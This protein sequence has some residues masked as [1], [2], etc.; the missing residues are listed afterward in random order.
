MLITA[1]PML[2]RIIYESGIANTKIG[3]LTISAAAFDDAVAW[4]MLAI[5][6]ATAKNS[7]AIAVLAIAGAIVYAV[8]MIFW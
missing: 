5:V 3:T 2:A 1:F 8:T 6:L 7:P 4:A